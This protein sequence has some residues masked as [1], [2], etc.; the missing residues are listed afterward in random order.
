MNR[1]RFA[2]V[3]ALLLQGYG[4]RDYRSDIMVYGDHVPALDNS[5]TP[6]NEFFTAQSDSTFPVT[7]IALRVVPGLS[8][9]RGT[10]S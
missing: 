2:L 6:F 5:G 8:H 7:S 9:P 10:L 3:T 1:L 4:Q